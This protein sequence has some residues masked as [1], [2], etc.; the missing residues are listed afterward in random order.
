MDAG[1]QSLEFARVSDVVLFIVPN[2][3]ENLGVGIEVGAVLEDMSEKQ[4]ER[5][6]FLH[7]KGMSSAMVGAIGD[8][9][10]ATVR[11]YEDESGLL[12]ETRLF[13]RDVMR[14]EGNGELERF[15]KSG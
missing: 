5:E 8:R 14:K 10:D 15:S 9:W 12:D 4:R 7:E 1:A 3:G 6:L 13:I 11:T 2:R